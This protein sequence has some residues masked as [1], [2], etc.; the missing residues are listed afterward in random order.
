MPNCH[1]WNIRGSR[2]NPQKRSF[3]P[4]QA[5]RRAEKTFPAFRLLRLLHKSD[6]PVRELKRQKPDRQR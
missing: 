5:Q 6:P 4:A 3:R 1:V 2:A